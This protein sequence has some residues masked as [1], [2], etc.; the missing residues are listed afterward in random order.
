MRKKLSCLV[1]VIMLIRL[2]S[3]S[4]VADDPYDVNGWSPSGGK[5]SLESEQPFW[6]SQANQLHR[7]AVDVEYESMSIQVASAVWDVNNYYYVV[8]MGHV[9]EKADDYVADPNDPNHLKA[10][11][12]FNLTV[13]NHSDLPVAAEIKVDVSEYL[14]VEQR[15]TI[16]DQP[17]SAKH[18]LPKVENGGQPTTSLTTVILAPKTDTD[19]E[20]IINSV[21]HKGVPDDYISPIGSVNLIITAK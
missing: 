3:L 5:T 20:K 11:F 13:I 6:V 4:A 16:N 8:K 15:T 9:D 18:E 2:F 17:V 19:W 12:S 10:P 21:I 7:Y 14:T 1:A